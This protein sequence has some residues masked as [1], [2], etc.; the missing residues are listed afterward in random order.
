YSGFQLN[1]F[2]GTTFVVRSVP[3]VISKGAEAE[4]LW[5]TPVQGLQ[6]Q[7]GVTYSDTRYGPDVLPDADLFLLPGSRV[8]FSPYWSSSAAL[9]YEWSF[10]GNLLGRFNIGAKHSSDYNT[11]SDLDPEKE[12]SA[13]TVVNARLGVGNQDQTWMLELWAQNLTDEEYI[14]VGFD[15]P[16]QSGSW[17][18]FLG[19][20]RTYGVTLRMAF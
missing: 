9:N 1:S 4:L 11:G 19:P 5:Q 8:S 17:N 15:A 7:A 18:A 14:Q 13:F 2:L 20:P 16:L 3:E 12:Q 10:A 6:L